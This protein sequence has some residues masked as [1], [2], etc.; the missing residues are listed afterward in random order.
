MSPAH[1]SKLHSAQPAAEALHCNR[2]GLYLAPHNEEKMLAN[3]LKV[4]GIHKP[5]YKSVASVSI[6]R[7]LHATFWKRDELPL[8]GQTD[9]SWVRMHES[10]PQFMHA[11]QTTQRMDQQSIWTKTTP[12]GLRHTACSR[13]A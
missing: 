7:M 4:R 9:I 11:R 8:S 6:S 1:S 2:L 12:G 13:A 3:G 10:Q 5:A